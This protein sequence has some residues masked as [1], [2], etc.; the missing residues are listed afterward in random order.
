MSQLQTMLLGLVAGLAILLGPPLARPLLTGRPA[1]RV[2][3]TA[4]TG[5]LLVFMLW[6]VLSRAFVPLNGALLRFYD[7]MNG[8]RDVWT[9]GALFLGGI[10][11]GFGLLI[12]VD[13]STRARGAQPP[14]STGTPTGPS[15]EE[16]W[17]SGGG[18]SV[19]TRVRTRTEVSAP[20]SSRLALST[21]IAV[22]LHNLGEGL[23]I[24]N[25]GAYGWIAITTMLVVA[26][27]F[28]NIV[29][30]FG[31]AAPLSSG[32][33]RPG[34]GY[35]TMLGLVA[36]L[37]TVLGTYLGWLLSDIGL[38]N[39]MVDTGVLAL[40]GGAILS[41]G[42]ALFT[43]VVKLGHR[44]ALRVGLLVGLAVAFFGEILLMAGSG[45]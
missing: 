30:G 11:A 28:Q 15:L 23:A 35:L 45:A 33:G 36:G 4:F 3:L 22:G 43:E 24:G 42:V 20:T 41:V 10:I 12:W 8:S 1:T 25:N 38:D 17:G 21:A 13:A 7:N 16:Q 5:G 9:F 26:L 29:A 40:A 31:I 37:P 39:D 14:F 18:G 44:T 27:V 19:A 2:F 6:N 34:G 32:V